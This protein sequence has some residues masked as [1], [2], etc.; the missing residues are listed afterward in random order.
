MATNAS[1]RVVLIAGPH[2]AGKSTV[3]P[4]IVRTAFGIEEFVNADAIATGLSGFAPERVAIRAGRLMWH[5]FG[6]SPRLDEDL[7][8][9]PPSRAVPSGLRSN[10]G[11]RLTTRFISCICT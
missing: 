9:K 4:E 5:G 1:S 10:I 6:S 7:P 11:Q 3:A 2:G 8:S